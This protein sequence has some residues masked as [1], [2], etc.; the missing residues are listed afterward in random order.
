M[1]RCNI[2]D[3]KYDITGSD[4]STACLSD[5]ITPPCLRTPN[6]DEISG[7]AADLFFS[8]MVDLAHY[9]VDI[10]NFKQVYRK[11]QERRR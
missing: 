9:D 4:I 3:C 2:D 5:L 6:K 1:L 7:K 10:K 11:L 8:T